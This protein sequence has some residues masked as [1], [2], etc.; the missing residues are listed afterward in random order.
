MEQEQTQGC[1]VLCE[2]FWYTEVS[3]R[4]RPVSPDVIAGDKGNWEIVVSLAALHI[5]AS[6]LLKRRKSALGL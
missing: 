1:P 4:A 6:V 5:P 3:P 2:P